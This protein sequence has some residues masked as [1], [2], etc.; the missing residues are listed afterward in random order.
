[1]SI[2]W[3]RPIQ[4]TPPQP[5][6]SR[7]ILILSTHLCLGLSSGLFPSGFHTNNL[8]TFLFT[9]IRAA[10]PTHVILLDLI[11][12]SI[13]GEEYKSRNSSLHN[14]CHLPGTPSLFG[15]YILLI[16]L[17]SQIYQNM[18]NLVVGFPIWRRPSI[19]MDVVMWE[20]CTFDCEVYATQGGCLVH[21][22]CL[23]TAVKHI[24]WYCFKTYI[25]HTCSP[26][27]ILQQMNVINN[28]VSFSGW[29]LHN[30]D[31][32]FSVFDVQNACSWAKP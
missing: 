5:I 4:S 29:K 23:L 30:P 31:L 2:S 32:R 24:V 9:P 17:P 16:T 6:S 7:S 18:V 11:I 1:L 22:C 8:H 3:A 10:C 27:V 13:L 12:L 21:L 25:I 19:L 26:F 20:L 15:P 28:G 14:F